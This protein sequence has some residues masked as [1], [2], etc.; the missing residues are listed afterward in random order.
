MRRPPELAV[1]L[2]EDLVSSAEIVE[3]VDVLRTKIDLQGGEYISR[4]EADFFG[5]QAID[6]GVD[7][8]RPG[9]E[10][11]EDSSKVGVFVRRVDQGICGAH[12]RLRAEPAPVLQHQLEPAGA[13]ETLHQ[14]C[15]N[16]NTTPTTKRMATKIVT[17]TSLIDLEMK[18]FGS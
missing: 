13:P 2:D 5:F 11:R 4:H 17:T 15:K 18:I 9:V 7:R 12:E 6:I 16:T 8:R 1:G 10:Q 14:F 3:V